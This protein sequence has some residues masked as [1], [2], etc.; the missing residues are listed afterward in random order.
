MRAAFL[1]LASVTAC[2]GVVDLDL[3][4][5]ATSRDGGPSVVGRDATPS[6]SVAAATPPPPVNEDTVRVV[7]SDSHFLI[8]ERSVLGALSSP[9]DH[10]APGT[11]E[12]TL[13][14]K[15]RRLLARRCFPSASGPREMVTTELI[16]DATS[17]L[18]RV[19]A[20]LAD[21]QEQK[22]PGECTKTGTM[23][24]L[25]VATPRGTNYF[26]DA[27]YDCVQGGPYR[28]VESLE[29]LDALFVELLD[30]R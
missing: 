30:S 3:G 21:L 20:V 14:V 10:C 2:G 9:N 24:T 17:E 28:Y 5:R 27:D 7:P 11:A 16:L 29:P 25:S 19:R 26:S 13:S 4:T 12:Y 1:L 8:L 15:S 6:S 23:R 18:V 22:R